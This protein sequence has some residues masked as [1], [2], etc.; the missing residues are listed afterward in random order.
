MVTTVIGDQKVPPVPA[1]D[2]C[3]A[4]DARLLR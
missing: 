3:M 2:P 1:L 4:Q